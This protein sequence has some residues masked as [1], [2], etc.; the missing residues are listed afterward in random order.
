MKPLDLRS[1]HPPRLGPPGLGG[2]GAGQETLEGFFDALGETRCEQ[3]RV[4]SADGAAWIGDTVTER[5]SGATLCID[6]FH[7]SR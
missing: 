4:V 1:C 7:V 2:G 6:A 5:C 3:I